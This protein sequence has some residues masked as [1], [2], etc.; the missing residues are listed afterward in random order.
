[1]NLGSLSLDMESRIFTL[2]G[3]LDDAENTSLR[4]DLN[5]PIYLNPEKQYMLGVTGFET[6][7]HIPN[8]TEK[9][10]LFIYRDDKNWRQGI[11]AITVPV[12]TYDAKDIHKYLIDN[13][14]TD[15]DLQ[16]TLNNNTGQTSLMC[17]RTVDFTNSRSIGYLFGFKNKV[18]EADE[19]HTSEG[20]IRIIDVNSLVILCNI[21]GGSYRQGK[22]THILHQFFPTVPPGYKIVERPQPVIYLPLNT[23]IIRELIIEIHDEH[24]RPIN[25]HGELVTITLHLKSV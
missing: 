21:V 19:W 18:L 25:F 3:L 17:G 20:V 7:N 15:A 23:T 10:N 4:V 5:P 8:V 16:I 6:Y 11:G 22:P 13:M 9:N 14:P 24:E 2:T 1:M 12:G